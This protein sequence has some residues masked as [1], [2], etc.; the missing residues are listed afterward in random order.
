MGKVI[1]VANQKGG[2]GKTTTSVNLAVSLGY[3]GKKVLLIDYDPQASSTVSLGIN[4]KKN[5]NTIENVI[6]GKIDIRKAIIELHDFSINII[7][8]TIESS[9][10]PKQIR[11]MK[12]DQDYILRYKIEKVKDAFDYILIDCPPS[13]SF[14]TLSALYGSDSVIIPVQCQFLA[15]DGL[16]QLL[17]TI[18]L[19]Q[20]NLKT[21][22]YDLKIEGILLTMLDK[23]SKAS[24]QIVNELKK[25]FEEG[26]FQ[27]IIPSNV[28]AQNAPNYGIPI[29]KYQKRSTSAKHYLLLAKEIIKNNEEQ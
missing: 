7:P 16:T 15:I 22:Q 3:Y 25:Y 8:T 4:R 6:L 5:Y 18:R 21:N 11:I 13:F 26:I 17:N 10:L 20:K 9:D 2:V 27:T 14:H 23:R 19:I 28:A 12:L 29:M 24:W 1:A